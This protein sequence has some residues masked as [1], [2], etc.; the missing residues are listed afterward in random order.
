MEARVTLALRDEL[1]DAQFVRALAY[2][3]QGGADVGECF[4]TARRIT[5]T[6]VDLWHDEWLATARRVERMADESAGAGHPVSARAAYFRASNYY[7]TAGIFLM[8]TPVDDRLRSSSAKQTETFRKGA[9]LLELPP[10][11]V[12]IPYEATTLPGYFFR[13]AVDDSGP[14]PTVIL[15]NGYDGTVEEMYFGNA[16]AALERGYHVL[17]FDGP[18][19]GSVILD[20]GIPFRPDWENVVTPVVDFALTLP[21]VDPA[22]LVLHGLSFGGYLAPRAA[23]AEHRLA[24]CVSDCG[25]YDLYDASIARVPGI[26]AHQVPDGNS[27]ALK[28]LESALDSTLKKPS[29][30][31]ALR[32]NLWVHDISTPLDFFRLAPEYTL[33][34]REQLIQCPTFV[35]ATEGDDL[36]VNASI[37]AD[38]LTCP[39]E[40]VLFSADDDVS[41]HCEM[42]GRSVFHQR[43]YD[44]LDGVLA[45]T[46]AAPAQVG[47]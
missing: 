33:K 23:T 21:G 4:G 15:T 42:S 47:G 31:W 3:Y 20:Q 5:K 11:I 39:K 9:A 2:T 25:P 41:G 19:Q 7:R 8:G 24:A 17:A 46:T 38:K 40:Y 16:V 36:S 43:V 10:D 22:R 32:R 14:R 44:W 12:D 34:N 30:G 37:L 28:I 26:L 29:A 13:T 1:F 18:G 27:V 6:D 35:C 45:K